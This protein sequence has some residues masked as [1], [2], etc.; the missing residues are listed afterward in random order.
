MKFRVLLTTA[1]LFTAVPVIPA[2]QAT[3]TKGDLRA[4]I[5]RLRRENA[6]LHAK[7]E[8]M[9]ARPG[10]ATKPAAED[11]KRRDVKKR[12]ADEAKHMEA[13]LKRI[14]VALDRARFVRRR[15]AGA[16]ARLLTN[17]LHKGEYQKA[18][19]ELQ[20]MQQRLQSITD[21]DAAMKAIDEANRVLLRARAA[22]WKQKQAAKNG[23]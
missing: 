16:M 7:I 5:E 8:K 19:A 4:E 10:Q 1:L 17:P 14:R 22:L 18:L 2:Q 12:Q 23:K 15:P 13:G 6:A 3:Q 20:Q 11:V 9:Q 21:V